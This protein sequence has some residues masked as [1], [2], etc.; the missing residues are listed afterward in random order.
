MLLGK[1]PEP[2]PVNDVL[3]PLARLVTRIVSDWLHPWVKS[4]NRPTP[5]RVVVFSSKPPRPAKPRPASAAEVSN[6]AE[7]VLAA[8]FDVKTSHLPVLGSWERNG[9]L[10]STWLVAASS[11]RPPLGGV[12]AAPS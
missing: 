5:V 8:M 7:N 6:W 3:V 12:H 1:P 9:P 2:T 11:G 4:A 10:A